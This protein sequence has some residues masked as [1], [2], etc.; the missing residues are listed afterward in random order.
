LAAG[1][2]LV[3]TCVSGG[4]DHLDSCKTA[5]SELQDAVLLIDTWYDDHHGSPDW[6][7]EVSTV[8]AAEVLEELT[9]A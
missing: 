7:R 2:T 8:L 5:R 1:N 9:H 4:F 3:A 6:R